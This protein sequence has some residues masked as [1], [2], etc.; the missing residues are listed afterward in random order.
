M[1]N[2]ARA[3]NR[4]R[5][6]SL[7]DHSHDRRWAGALLAAVL[8]LAASGVLWSLALRLPRVPDATPVDPA[9]PPAWPPRAPA[10]DA[11]W[12]FFQAGSDAF[13]AE[14]GHLASRFRLAGWFFAYESDVAHARRAIIDDLAAD[15]QH[16]V[17]EGDRVAG[18]EVVRIFR[19]RVILREGAREEELWLSFSQTEEPPGAQTHATADTA[20][21]ESWSD[22][23]P[24]RFG[25]TRVGER[26]WVFKRD[27]LIEYYQELM[28][29]PERLVRTFDSLK[30]LYNTEGKITGYQLG[31]EGEADFF[32]AAGLEENDIVRSVNSLPMT[33]RGRAEYFIREFVADRANA[34]VLQIE[35]NGESRKLIYQMR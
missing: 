14:N 10:P 24:N 8:S 25:I 35:R 13:V 16:I 3:V 18:A 17:R 11:D 29:E 20:G 30:P 15:E 4:I 34:F 27:K 28:D 9:W 23:P 7:S 32:D 19:N 33:N 5:L 26:S 31:I 12:S 22:A 2:T 1:T 21:S 6:M